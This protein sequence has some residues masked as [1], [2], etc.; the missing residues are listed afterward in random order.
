MI[1][2]A[3]YLSLEYINSLFEKMKKVPV[4]EYD[5]ETLKV[6]QLFTT[7]ALSKATV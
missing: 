7:T 5:L 2:L 6:V 4:T 3:P 1:D